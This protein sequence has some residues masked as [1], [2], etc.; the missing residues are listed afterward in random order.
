MIKYKIKSAKDMTIN[1]LIGQV[2]MVGLPGDF[3][4]DDYKKFI[5]D[6]KIG[7]YILFA[8]NYTDSKQMKSFMKDLYEYT[9]EVTNSYPL[10]SIDQ[11]GGMVVRLFKDVTFPASP[12]TTSATSYPNAPYE[13]GRIIGTDMLK[14]GISINLA[15]C[16]EIN[17]NLANPL[18]NVRG[19]GA[20]KE[21]VL[22]NATLFVEGIKESG[23]LSCIKHF[24]GAGRNA[25][26]HH[27]DRTGLHCLY[28]RQ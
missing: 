24:P 11:E 21:I 23:A 9:L 5:K 6:K 10:V 14:H 28:H 17:E 15:P 27:P 2:I 13:T 16:L 8:R 3:L 26:H 12:L 22:Q 18:V 19:Y 1:E 4:D 25:Q 7:N 20:T